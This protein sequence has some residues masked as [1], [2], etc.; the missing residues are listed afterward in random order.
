EIESSGGDVLALIIFWTIFLNFLLIGLE[1]MGLQAAVDPLRNIIAFLPRL[2]SALIMLVLGAMLAQFLGRTA[3]AAMSG[4]GVE[5]H[6]QVGQIVNSL[7]LVMVVIVILQQLGLDASIMINIVTSVIVLS[8]A[9]FALAFGF[10]G[11]NVARNVLAGYYAREHFDLGDT[12]MLNGEEGTLEDIGT[13]NSLIQAGDKQ[14]IIPNTRLTE[15][16]TAKR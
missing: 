3:S 14:L 4:M 2:I 12:I 5:F 7:I 13:L 1:T 16:M 11:Q 10:G 15:E 8:V 6:Q 9:G